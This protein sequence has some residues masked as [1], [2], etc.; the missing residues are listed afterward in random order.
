MPLSSELREALARGRRRPRPS[1]RSDGRVDTNHQ[2]NGNLRAAD[3]ATD[4]HD[5]MPADDPDDDDSAPRLSLTLKE[6]SLDGICALP[7]AQAEQ[8]TG[9]SPH[10]LDQSKALKSAPKATAGTTDIPAPPDLLDP[11]V[12][13]T[14]PAKVAAFMMY[15]P[16]DRPWRYFETA[17]EREQRES[18][19][20]TGSWCG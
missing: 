17:G 3:P 8:I 7:A 14:M 18:M 9:R 10:T 16:P 12:L 4:H 15:E 1:S 20:E 2:D 11:A 6:S 19:E 13:R 5:A